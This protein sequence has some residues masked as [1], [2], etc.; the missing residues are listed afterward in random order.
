MS[1]HA[2]VLLALVIVGAVFVP[3]EVK[4]DT[5]ADYVI[6]RNVNVAPGVNYKKVKDSKGPNR[7]F[8]LTVNPQKAVTLDVALAGNHLGHAE[9]T[10][11]MASRHNA[12]AAINGD[13]GT[14]SGRPAFGFMEDGHLKIDPTCCPTDFAIRR[15]EKRAYFGE[16]DFGMTLW[17][18]DSNER[19]RIHRWNR[20][21]PSGNEI[22]AYTTAGGSFALPPNAGCSA[23]LVPRGGLVWAGSGLGREYAV[24]R[25]GC[26]D[27]R[28]PRQNAV[29]LSADRGTAQARQLKSLK[30]GER[31]RLLWTFGWPGIMENMGGTP[32]LMRGGSIVARNCRASLCARHPRTGIGR[33]A[34]G[35]LLLIVV[36]GRRRASV[37]MTLVEF[38]RLFKS[39]GATHALNLD[40]GGSSTMVVKGSIKNVPSDGRERPVINALLVLPGPDRREAAPGSG[41][42]TAGARLSADEAGDDQ[43]AVR[44]GPADSIERFRSAAARDA[45]S[46]GGMVDALAR[47]SLGRRPSALPPD[48]ISLLR[49]FRNRPR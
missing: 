1:K 26:H 8:I 44:L 40:G 39:L 16:P 22:A 12:V 48:F 13:F 27:R 20:R 34:D 49:A 7:I 21:T 2:R 18:L 11:S 17:E 38:A 3:T 32:V 45:A 15:N 25:A 10:T 35:R 4:P 14:W 5:F 23:R 29:V 6:L 19:W 33:R 41:F 46:A 47:G 24:D 31:V 43:P 9:R 42:A 28:F 36:D 37:G 30:A